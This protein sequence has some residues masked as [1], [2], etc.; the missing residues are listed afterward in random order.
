MPTT[1]TKPKYMT[2]S[3]VVCNLTWL[4]WQTGIQSKSIIK[5]NLLTIYY[6][7]SSHLSRLNVLKGIMNKL[8]DIQWKFIQF[9]STCLIIRES[10]NDSQITSTLHL[11]PQ[12]DVSHLTN[13][14]HCNIDLGSWSTLWTNRKHRFMVSALA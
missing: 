3:I 4:L 10:T 11:W 9:R 6:S 8:A 2:V 12:R 13:Y 5:H 1:M 7:L 14:K